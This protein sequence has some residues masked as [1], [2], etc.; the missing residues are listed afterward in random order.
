MAIFSLNQYKRGNKA[1]KHSDQSYVFDIHSRYEFIQLT[2]YMYKPQ[3]MNG[4]HNYSN[5]NQVN[6]KFYS[7]VVIK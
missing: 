6:N 1:N 2:T 7:K 4:L 3:Y 5:F